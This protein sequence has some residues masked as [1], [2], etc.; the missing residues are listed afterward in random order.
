MLHRKPLHHNDQYA[1]GTTNNPYH[2]SPVRNR[3]RTVL[4]DHD[5][6]KTLNQSAMRRRKTM[7]RRIRL[8]IITFG[9]LSLLVHGYYEAR[10]YI[11]SRVPSVT[12]ENPDTSKLR[13][14]NDSSD[15]SLIQ[16]EVCF[17]TSSYSKKKKEM[18]KLLVVNN[19]SPY[20]RFYLFTNMNDDEWPTPGWTKIVT[21][22]KYRRIITHSRYGK[23]LGWKEPKI[24]AC[25][26]V[27]Y[28]DACLRPSENQTMW[29]E[30]AEIIATDEVGLMQ[31]PH[32][33]NRTGVIGEFLA[34]KDSKKDID[35]NIVKSLQ[36]MIAQDD[37]D[38]NATIYMNENFGYDPNSEVYQKLSQAFWDRYSLEEGSWRDQPL[39]A[40]MLHRYNITPIPY[41]VPYQQVWQRNNG[42][43]LGHHGHAYT[44]EKDVL[45]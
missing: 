39:W 38:V 36:W 29:R 45:A 24:Q 17:V 22:F 27:F 35:K 16:P 26:A 37:L 43:S 6:K 25:K 31:W 12:F 2:L 21:H 10:R 40:F 3:P 15:T 5:V 9:I 33:K 7:Y 19:K 42:R 23:F 41:P 30:L 11:Q 13:G 8:L 20:L 32:P 28:M 18:D 44:S 34:I 4:E 14:Y 1:N